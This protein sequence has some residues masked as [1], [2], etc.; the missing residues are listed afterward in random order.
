LQVRSARGRG[1]FWLVVVLLLLSCG[2]F[3]H[4]VGGLLGLGLCAHSNT[5]T[6]NNF[7]A[8]TATGGNVNAAIERLLSS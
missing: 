2:L 4:C 5:N 3:C 7:Q 1:V 6:C 8:L